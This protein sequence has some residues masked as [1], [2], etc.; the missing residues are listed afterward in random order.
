MRRL[1]L[2]VSLLCLAAAP[3]PTEPTPDEAEKLDKGKIVLRHE[4]TDQGGRVTAI[5][6]VKAAPRTVL[7]AVMDLEARPDESSVLT[8]VD[9]YERTASPDVTGAKFLVT[10]MG[11]QTVFHI[12]YDCHRD[13][14]YC[15]YALDPSKDND[16]VSSDGYYLVLPRGSGSRLYYSS[17][18]V[19]GRSLPGWVQRWL[20]GNALEGQVEGVRKR[21][22][23]T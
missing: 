12:R 8:S 22:E 13:D 4:A 9:V 14:G 20:A 10:V 2:A 5:A 19:T 11:S 7:D 21:A 18:T 1:L 6:D 16:I 15:T 17:R 23:G 3:T